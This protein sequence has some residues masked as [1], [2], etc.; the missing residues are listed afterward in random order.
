MG[1]P[2]IGILALQTLLGN[3]AVE[4]LNNYSTE[5]FLNIS[6]T[7]RYDYYFD[8]ITLSY[9]EYHLEEDITNGTEALPQCN[10]SILVLLSFV[11]FL[12]QHFPFLH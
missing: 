12:L 10:F 5:N 11:H 8:N 4:E 2:L 9:Y 7:F 1:F 3:A 6:G